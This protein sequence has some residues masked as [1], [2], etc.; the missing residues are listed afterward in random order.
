MCH[1]FSQV[2]QED[3][4]SRSSFQVSFRS[5]AETH[6]AHGFHHH[7]RGRRVLWIKIS[8]LWYDHCPRHLLTIELERP[9]QTKSRIKSHAASGGGFIPAPGWKWTEMGLKQREI[10]DCCGHFQD[11]GSSFYTGRLRRVELD[12]V[13][14]TSMLSAHTQ[15]KLMFP[16]VDIF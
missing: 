12:S 2:V 9:W 10:R 14:I 3:A 13:F 16:H 7:W 1:H 6:I 11:P 8:R 5:V 4:A 15:A